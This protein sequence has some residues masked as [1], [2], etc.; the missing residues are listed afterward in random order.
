[1]SRGLGKVQQSMADAIK[2][3]PGKWV[4]TGQLAEAAYPDEEIKDW[5]RSRVCRALG[6]LEKDMG[7]ERRTMGVTNK[8]G[9]HKEV[10]F[11]K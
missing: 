4:T 9:F 3:V 6:R 1:M 10:M 7:L 5:H 8:R 11:P 2:A